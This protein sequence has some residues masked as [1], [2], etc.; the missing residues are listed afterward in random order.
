MFGSTADRLAAIG[1]AYRRLLIAVVGL[2][3]IG[4][5]GDVKFQPLPQAASL[6]PS[7]DDGCATI[8]TEFRPQLI[9]APA[10][11]WLF[12]AKIYRVSQRLFKTGRI[13]YP[14]SRE[15]IA[16]AGAGEL[17]RVVARY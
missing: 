9:D 6:P 2:A 15:P 3:A 16:I 10:E 13:D 14:C 4:S 17:L 12:S 1:K 8:R 7:R 11:Q 5:F